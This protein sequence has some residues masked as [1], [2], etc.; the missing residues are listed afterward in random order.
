MMRKRHELRLKIK[1]I[2]A[3]TLMTGKVLVFLPFLVIAIVLYANPN[4][5][6]SMTSSKFGVEVIVFTIILFIL[7]AF[8][9]FRLSR[10]KA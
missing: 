3:E 5:L 7:G 6:D 9:I 10:I 1:A 4:H 2:S 8:L